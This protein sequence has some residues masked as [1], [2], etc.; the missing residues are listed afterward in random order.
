MGTLGNSFRR[1]E[2]T[3]IL[4][5]ID[6]NLIEV[7]HRYMVIHPNVDLD[8]INISYLNHTSQD[9]IIYTDSAAIAMEAA[10]EFPT[11][12]LFDLHLK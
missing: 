10:N 6:E 8:V 5:L 9:I 1:I 4:K 2:N 3:Y 7:W 11:E 12:L